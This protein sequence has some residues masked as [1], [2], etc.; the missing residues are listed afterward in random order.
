MAEKETRVF[1]TYVSTL[2]Q[3]QT[4]M[5]GARAARR[6]H[7][8]CAGEH[9]TAE[10]EAEPRSIEKTPTFTVHKFEWLLAMDPH[11]TWPR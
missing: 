7:S 9:T 4:E 8:E 6:K 3:I 2:R 10:K 5:F 11:K 1:L